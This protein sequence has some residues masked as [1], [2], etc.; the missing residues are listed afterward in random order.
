VR[1]EIFDKKKKWQR[2]N[3]ENEQEITA[4]VDIWR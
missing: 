1:R 3:S 4:G 2:E